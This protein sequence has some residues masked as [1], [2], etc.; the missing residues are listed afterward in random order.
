MSNKT[1]FTPE[2]WSVISGA[3]HT[4]AMAI[5]S[6]G[7]GVMGAMKEAFSAAQIMAG[8]MNSSN[9]LIR[10]ICKTEEIKA[11]EK[12]LRDMV[13][14]DPTRAGETLKTNA[15]GQVKQAMALIAKKSAAD[16]DAYRTFITQIA[17]AVAQAAKEGGFLGFGGERVSAGETDILNSL[18]AAMAS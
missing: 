8:S 5:A 12:A 18:K 10:S 2:E 16:S 14:A 7:G 3:P 4:V 15:S 17:D 6:A 9:E 11:A 13:M 1:T